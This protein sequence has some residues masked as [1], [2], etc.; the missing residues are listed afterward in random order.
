MGLFAGVALLDDHDGDG[1]Y[2]NFRVEIDVDAPQGPQQV[3]ASVGVRAPGG[4]WL[5]ELDT[6]TFTV[7]GTGRHDTILID[8]AWQSG[9]PPAHYD[10][11]ITVH[12]ADS[13]AVLAELGPE[14]ANL[15]ALPLED[16]AS[17]HYADP[18]APPPQRHTVSH[19]H[20]GTSAAGWLV[21]GLLLAAIRRRRAARA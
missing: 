9:Y 11:L 10:F 7:D 18:V 6:A 19:G 13:S 4:A 12:S 1:Y 16:A 5:H 21:P 15:S 8:G 3:Y 2:H 20:G 17:D 14:S